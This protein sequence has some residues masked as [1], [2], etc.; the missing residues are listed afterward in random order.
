[1]Q[2]EAI[3]MVNSQKAYQILTAGVEQMPPPL[4]AGPPPQIPLPSPEKGFQKIAATLLVDPVGNLPLGSYHVSDAYPTLF[5]LMA[6]Y[7]LIPKCS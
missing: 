4:L 3:E 1:M 5:L 6:L 7:Q 2:E